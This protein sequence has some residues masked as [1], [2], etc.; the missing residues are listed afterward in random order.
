MQYRNAENFIF[1]SIN[2]EI[3]GMQK[4]DRKTYVFLG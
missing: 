4:S 1:E 3:V 2:T